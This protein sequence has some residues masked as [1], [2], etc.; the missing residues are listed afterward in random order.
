MTIAVTGATGQLG[1]QVV[2]KLKQAGVVPVALARDPSK[3]AD[4]GV[5]TRLADYDRPETLTPALAGVDTLL[6]ISSSEVGKR[7]AQHAAVIDAAVAAG[8]GHIVYT[9]ILNAP[10]NPISLAAEHRATEAA[11]AASG[12]TTTILRNGWYSENYAASLPAAVAN[13]AVIGSAGEGLISGAARED[14]ADA[15]VAVLTG[16]GHEGKVYELAGDAAFRL[17]DLAAEA[18]LQTGKDI[19]YVDMPA[20]DYAA[21]LEKIGLDGGLA[22]AIAGWDVDAAGGALYSSDRTLSTLIGRP[23]TPLPQVVKAALA[24]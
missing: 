18:S 7:A 10:D 20:Q 15:A 5:E 3:A 16:S 12:L 4:L 17:S 9:S 11:L 1:R 24:A 13:G 14:F 22:A 23:T 2:G 6:L 19:G 8:V 21:V